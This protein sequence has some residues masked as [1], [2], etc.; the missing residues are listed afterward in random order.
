MLQLTIYRGL[1]REIHFESAPPGLRNDWRV[2]F[3]TRD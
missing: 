1:S 2:R 3:Y